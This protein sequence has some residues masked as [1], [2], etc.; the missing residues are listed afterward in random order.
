M[1]ISR[2]AKLDDRSGPSRSIELRSARAALAFWAKG[3][4]TTAFSTAWLSRSSPTCTVGVYAPVAVH[5]ACN[6]LLDSPRRAATPA[7]L[8]RRIAELSERDDLHPGTGRIPAQIFLRQ[9]IHEQ[10]PIGLMRGRGHEY[11][12]C[13]GCTIT[14]GSWIPG[15]G[16]V[17]A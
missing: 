13:N 2:G 7:I 15:C 17:S 10:L 4:M 1:S 16:R 5:M 3:Y 6:L 12:G 14:R 11:P 9:L 8:G